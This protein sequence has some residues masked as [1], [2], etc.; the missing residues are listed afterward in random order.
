MRHTKPCVHTGVI[1]FWMV[2]LQDYCCENKAQTAFSTGCASSGANSRPARPQKMQG[3]AWPAQA[4]GQPGL[5]LLLAITIQR[6]AQQC[7]DILR[8]RGGR[9][10]SLG[11]AIPDQAIENASLVLRAK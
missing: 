4:S 3:K 2:I 8:Y 5:F 10:F 9:Y 6:R 11:K 7:F 1:A